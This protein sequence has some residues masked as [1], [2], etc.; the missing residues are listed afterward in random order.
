MLDIKFIRENV[1]LV[2]DT[3]KNKGIDLNIDRLLDIHT[4]RSTMQKNIDDLNSERKKIASEKNFEKGKQ[5]KNDLRTITEKFKQKDEEFK[6]LMLLTP[7]IPHKN[8]PVGTDENSNVE[9]R[10]VGKKPK[11]NKFKD[12]IELAKDLDLIDFERGVKVSGFRGYF[13]KNE[14]AVMQ[15]ALLEMARNKMIKAGFTIMIPPALV[16][17]NTLYGTGYF[18]FCEGDNYEIKNVNEGKDGTLDKDRLYLAGTAEVAIG[19]YHSGEV[20]EEDQLPL[21]Y[22]GFNS[23]FRREVG[24]YGRDTKGIYR[25]HEF[26]KIEQFVICRNDYTESEKWHQKLIALSEE[27]L[28]ELKLPYRVIEMCTGDM[29]AGKYKMFDIETWMPSRKAYGET[30]SASN[31]GD[32]QARRLNIKYKDKQGKKHYVHTLNNTAIAS[33]RILIALL[34]NNQQPDGS[35]KIPKALQKY[36][37]G[38]KVIK[39]K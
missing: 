38:I 32:W 22:C 36:M 11:F 21:T 8:V 28:Q 5:I 18:P 9:V 19:A 4:A 24:S 30:H 13:L 14:A 10:V 37:N 3:V 26:M 35:V 25:I 15:M 1:D 29:G 33:P 17:E 7:Q 34:E 27:M 39:K 20:L 31:L 16:K 2:K 6:N 23:C 12:H